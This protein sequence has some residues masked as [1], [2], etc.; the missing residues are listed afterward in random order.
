MDDTERGKLFVTEEQQKQTVAQ[1]QAETK[2]VGERLSRIGKALQ[3]SPNLVS[4]MIDSGDAVS[5][6]PGLPQELCFSTRDIPSWIEI[7]ALTQSLR[8]SQQSLLD[9]KRRLGT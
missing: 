1:F 7:H 3:E 5:V 9:T 8:D 6:S 4:F 2:R